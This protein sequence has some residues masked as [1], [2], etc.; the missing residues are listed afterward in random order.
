[1]SIIIAASPWDAIGWLLFFLLMLAVATTIVAAIVF[2][3]AVRE[4]E[5]KIKKTKED[6]IEP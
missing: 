6:I 1:M 2:L 5:K 3:S 4:H